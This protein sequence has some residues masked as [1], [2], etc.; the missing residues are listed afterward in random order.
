MMKCTLEVDPS[1]SYWTACAENSG[2]VSK[3][4]AFG[5]SLFGS[6]SFLR[7]ERLM[8]DM[9]HRYDTFPF[10]LA[11]LGQWHPMDLSDQSLICH[12]HTQLADPIYRRFTGEYLVERYYGPTGTVDNDLITR[13]IDTVVP[14]R[15]Q[16]ATR[17]KIASKMLTSALTAG[18]I[19]SNRNPRLISFPKVSD[20]ALSY[21][22]FVLKEIEYDGTAI[23]NLYLASVGLD[24]EEAI[25]RLRNIK[26]LGFRRQGSLVN[27]EWQY[28]SMMDWAIASELVGTEPEYI[29]Q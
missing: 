3:E 12:W 4:Y 20:R 8:A 27:F 17:K 18:I 23:S 28:K 25:R 2:C 14:G 24:S 22:M 13:W 10:A 9:R 6:K 29:S 19:S 7:V 15:W 1:R 26:N 5:A 11:V 21:L 16:I